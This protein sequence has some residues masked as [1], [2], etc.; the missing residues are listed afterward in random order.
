MSRYIPA[1]PFSSSRIWDN[2][3]MQLLRDPSQTGYPFIC[4]WRLS[5]DE[6]LGVVDIVAAALGDVRFMC[7]I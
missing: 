3:G 4:H 6:V 5:D 7:L 2:M 1:R